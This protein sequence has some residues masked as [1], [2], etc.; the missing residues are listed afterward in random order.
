MCGGA[1]GRRDPTQ[2]RISD[3]SLVTHDRLSSE[4]RKRL[5][6]DHDSPRGDRKFRLDCVW[7]PEI[8]V[9][10]QPDGTVCP[11]AD[12]APKPGE[13]RRLNCDWGFGSAAFVTG[14]FG[15]AAAARAVERI[16]AGRQADS[17]PRPVPPLL[18]PH[19]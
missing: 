6:H 11:A 10:P 2:V 13:S 1:G 7:S 8:P 18:P 3:L 14:A 16:V 4:V 9:F 5:R 17:T 15:F 19:E 12:A